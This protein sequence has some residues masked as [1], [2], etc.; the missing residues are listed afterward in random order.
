MLVP[1]SGRGTKAPAIRAGRRSTDA[2]SR[3]AQNGVALA[4]QHHRPQGAVAAQ[5]GGGDD[6]L[7]EQVEGQRVQ[8]LGAVQAH[9]CDAVLHGAGDVAGAAGLA[10][11]GIVGRGPPG[12]GLRHRGKVVT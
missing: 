7:A 10:H 11:G 4:G 12:T 6:Q 5:P 1:R 9:L 3:P 8:L 2:K